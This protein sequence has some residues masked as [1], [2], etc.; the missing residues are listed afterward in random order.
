LTDFGL[1]SLSPEHPDFKPFYEGDPWH[2]DTA[3][4]QG[5]VWPFLLGEYIAAYLKA[6]QWSDAALKRALNLLEPLKR[7]FY[8]QECI[9][10]I[11]EVFDGYMPKAGKGA[12]HQAWSLGAIAKTLIDIQNRQ[13]T[14]RKTLKLPFLETASLIF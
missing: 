1:R 12:V 14:P 2:R 9:L 10:G 4:H 3:Y 6:A 11:S 13:K 5:T 7:H 8:Q